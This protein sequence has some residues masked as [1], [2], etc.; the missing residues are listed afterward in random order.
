MFFFYN[1]GVFKEK[2]ETNK[3]QNKFDK[4]KTLSMKLNWMQEWRR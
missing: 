3:T 2:K 1:A 4:K